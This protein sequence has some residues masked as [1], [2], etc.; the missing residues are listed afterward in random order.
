MGNWKPP[1]NIRATAQA[2]ILKD[3]QVLVY[4]GFDKLKHENFY[5]PI[6]GT[7][8]FL[9]LAKDTVIREFKEEAGIDVIEPVLLDVL[10]NIFTFE[11]HHGH[12][13]VQVFQCKFKDDSLYAQ[14]DFPLVEGDISLENA[15]W[16]EI[17]FLIQPQVRFFPA[18]MKEIVARLV[19][20]GS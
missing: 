10:E 8:E 14:K 15:V 5:R 11:G 1:Q 9:E 16:K 18:G 19:K 6:G 13:I 3:D 17:S 2:V 20:S 7:V 12:E 4:E